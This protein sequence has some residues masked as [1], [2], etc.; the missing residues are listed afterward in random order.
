VIPLPVYIEFNTYTNT[1]TNID[2]LGLSPNVRISP[3][4]DLAKRNRLKYVP[5]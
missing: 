2:I 5:T 4:D 3:G 1:Y